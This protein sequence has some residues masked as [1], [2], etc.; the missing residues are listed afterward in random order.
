MNWTAFLDHITLI[1]PN[2]EM[3]GVKNKCWNFAL[4]VGLGHGSVPTS[5]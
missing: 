2:Y 3:A 4:L 5:L 1:A